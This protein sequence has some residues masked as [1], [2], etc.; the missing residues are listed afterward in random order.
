M[1]TVNMIPNSDRDSDSSF[2]YGGG[3]NAP[4]W[5]D[6]EDAHST[7]MEEYYL[8][9]EQAEDIKESTQLASLR[10]ASAIWAKDGVPRTPGP[11]PGMPGIADPF[12]SSPY[13]ADS[14]LVPPPTLSG[15]TK[16]AGLELDP[17]WSPR[18]VQMQG[19]ES[20]LSFDHVAHGKKDYQ[21]Q[22]VE[23]NFTDPTGQYFDQYER[24]LDDL[25]L[26]EKSEEPPPIEEYLVK[27]EKEWYQRFYDVKM[28]KSDGGGK[29]AS[30]IFQ[31]TPSGTT[32]AGSMFHEGRH[33]EHDSDDG[34]G[35]FLLQENYA[36]PTGFKKFLLIKFR[37]WPIYSFL[38]AFVSH[39][40]TFSLVVYYDRMTAI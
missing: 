40:L 21:L 14:P 38:L 2:P 1:A 25:D 19:N 30:S 9:P 26:D 22:K 17:G 27:S 6:H 28:G 12:L 15:D 11:V 36:P 7:F 8:T 32:P 33:D 13:Y 34:M 39:I 29:R 37:D 5:D 10:Q 31:P 35:Q 18:D 24:L 4:P 3:A 20:T 23:P 16:Y